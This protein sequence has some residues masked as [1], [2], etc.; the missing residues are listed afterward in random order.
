MAN[1]LST[2][3]IE[4]KTIT[5]DQ[6]RNFFDQHI[7]TY[8][9]YRDD[10]VYSTLISNLVEYY[11]NNMYNVIP[12]ELKEFI[13]QYNI[14]NVDLYDR[15]LVDI[16]V[17]NTLIQQ[18]TYN[19]KSIFLK[20]LVDFYQYKSTLKFVQNVGEAYIE[21]DR[22]NIY[23]LY[24]D[25]D[26][27]REQPWVLKPI[28]IHHHDQVNLT[29]ESLDYIDAYER[30]PSLLIDPERLSVMR[31]DNQ[32]VLPI[33][34]NILFLDY[35]LSTD[36]STLYSL[37]VVT[38]LKEYKN[39]Y[40]ELYFADGTSISSKLGSILFA[41]FYLI[42]QYHN[43]DWPAIGNDPIYIPVMLTMLYDSPTYPYSI[44]DLDGLITDYNNITT[45]TERDDFYKD[46]LAMK[47]YTIPIVTFQAITLIEMQGILRVLDSE[48]GS[49]LDLKISESVSSIEDLLTNIY[50]SLNVYINS[51]LTPSDF[52]KYSE[53]FIKFLPQIIENPTLT[54]TYK[55]LQILKPFHV[56]LYTRFQEIISCD[57]KFNSIWFETGDVNYRFLYNAASVFNASDISIFSTVMASQNDVLSIIDSYTITDSIDWVDNHFYDIDK[58]VN[59]TGVGDYIAV[60]A[61]ISGLVAPTWTTTTGDIIVDNTVQWMC[62]SV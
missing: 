43:Y 57:D 32:L 5:I 48:L 50:T 16:G 24:I 14:D 15:L 18:L 28:N 47:F 1:E 29:E 34:S 60:V 13:E 23:E 59:I 7:K 56:E 4:T 11:Y 21:T 58:G 22:I 62:I 35:T 9:P 20:S 46:K 40:I 12:Q 33:K 2:T 17:P 31:D 45:I 42:S 26:F 55:I 19:E 51:S 52:K 61:G 49:Y 6:I 27:A 41:W 37:I 3:L 54:P 8:Y 39:T 44:T 53:Y 25:Y 38:F 10:K 30:I 36:V